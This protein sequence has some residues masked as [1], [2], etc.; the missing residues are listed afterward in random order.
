MEY[1]AYMTVPHA[2]FTALLLTVL[3]MLCWGSW[4]N[5]VKIVGKWRFE[6]LY[7]D[8]AF[9]ILL[10][11]VVA[12]LTFGSMG[13]DGLPFLDDLETAG[14]WNMLYGFAGGVI[15]NLANFLIVGAIAVAGL[16]VAFPVGVGLALVVGVVWNYFV[17]PQG[18]PMLLFTGVALVVAAIVTDAIAYRVH[19]AATA[20][21][22]A[23]GADPS[24]AKK[25]TAKGLLLSVIGGLLMGTFY[26]LVELGKQGDGGL[27]PYG[28]GFIFSLGIFVSTFAFGLY[29]MKKPVQGKPLK[30]R[31]YFRGRAKVHFLGIAGGLMWA[32]GTL[33][34]FI[35][36]SAP[37]ELQVGPA[38][39]YAL[40]QGATMVGAFWGVFIWK[41]FAGGGKPVNRLIFLMFVLFLSGLG[42][43]SIAPLYTVR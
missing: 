5:V 9:G 3:T 2:Y 22:A 7:F 42:L 11:S 18:N 33:S 25:R 23:S 38:V 34:S 16:G 37:K 8:Y 26:P 39:S 35:A 19:A 1:H 12:G 41:E 4:A 6:L 20:A 10:A 28:V 36:A 17:N 15:F 31:A 29:F 30:I 27:G 13:G 24:E 43:V 14:H 32:T 21:S 40:G